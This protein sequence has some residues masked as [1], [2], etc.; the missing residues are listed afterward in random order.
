MSRKS[1]KIILW[2]ALCLISLFILGAGI[3][4]GVNSYI[5]SAGGN[6]TSDLNKLKSADVI[7]VLGAR[8]YSDGSPSPALRDRLDY[9]Y[10]A[11][12]SGLS[13]YILCSGD[14]GKIEYNEV[15]GMQNYLVE[16][17]VPREDIILDYA[18]FDTYDS[19]YR[20]RDIFC[21]ES[22]IVVTQEYH[23][24]RALYIADKLGM[25]SY[26]YSAPDSVFGESLR[27]NRLRESLARVKAFLD[28]EVF[29]SE[30]TFLGD[31]LP[32]YNY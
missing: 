5:L 18:G 24:S 12:M 3:L 6:Y 23:M 4:W 8:V 26:G 11:Y 13:K 19:M 31:K 27:S 2:V 21:V 30:P 16:R 10:D 14:N 9:G 20:A 15:I 29:K 28:V 1:K 25:K 32:F 17:G 7:L 22:M